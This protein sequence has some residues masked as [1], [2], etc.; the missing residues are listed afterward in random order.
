VLLTL[1]KHSVLAVDY[2]FVAL[3]KYTAPS[4]SQP[5]PP[6]SLSPPPQTPHHTFIIEADTPFFLLSGII[7]EVNYLSMSQHSAS[8]WEIE[9]IGISIGNSSPKS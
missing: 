4:P 3:L 8:V 7:T 9:A 6:F 5:H 1:P 2:I